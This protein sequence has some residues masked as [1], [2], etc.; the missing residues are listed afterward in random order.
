M[1]TLL[2]VSSLVLVVLG[3]FLALAAL[4]RLTHWSGRRELQL[5]VLAAPIISLGLGL[6]GLHH[7][8]GR[9]CFIGA[10]PWDYTLGVALPLAMSLVA[11]GALGLG[12]V[13][14]ALL[15]RVVSRAGTFADQE[16]QARADRLAE[17]LG[18]GRA[19]RPRVLLC[20]CRRPLALTFG[21]GRPIVLIS[22]WMLERLDRRELEAVLA[23]EL[24]H[25]A[26]RDWLVMW[27]ALV[28]RDAFF[29]LPT[30]WAAY[31]QLQSEKEL[32]CDDLAVGA[33]RRPLALASALTKVWQHAL[34]APAFGPAGTPGIAGIVAA[35][36]PLVGDG[37]VS[38]A[39]E[40]RV[41][42]LLGPTEPGAGTH[43]QH[44][45]RRLVAFGI[46]GSSLMALLA[47]E[48][49]NAAVMLAPMGCGPGSPLALLGRLL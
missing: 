33:T 8:A 20:T 19:L 6:G 9:I 17:Q 30:S 41:V 13:R 36:E 42:R 21:L 49:A 32:A 12:L 40:A 24:G 4:R 5:L 16:L 39:I 34:G 45:H 23:H 14:L 47:L 48:A 37:D 25:V 27:L 3:G 31:R 2:G 22:T 44:Q 1:H 26:Q 29:Y 35:V 28:L 46:G 11:L 38:Q 43:H 18:L 15:H 10:P 7:F